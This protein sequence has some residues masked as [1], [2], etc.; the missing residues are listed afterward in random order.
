[1]TSKIV[2]RSTDVEEY[3]GVPNHYL[4][5]KLDNKQRKVDKHAEKYLSSFM[6]K[7]EAEQ[8]VTTVAGEAQPFLPCVLGGET[9]ASRHFDNTCDPQSNEEI[10]AFFTACVKWCV[11]KD[12]TM[13]LVLACHGSNSKENYKLQFEGDAKLVVP[14]SAISEGVRSARKKYPSFKCVGLIEACYANYFDVSCFDASITGGNGISRPNVLQDPLL[15]CMQEE[16]FTLGDIFVKMSEK[17]ALLQLFDCGD[18]NVANFTSAK[19][20]GNYRFKN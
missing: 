16:E 20:N 10:V 19:I 1:M 11:E 7:D 13:L 8:Q 6:S 18:D 4:T 12:K 9:G 15:Q 14:S 2:K 5:R 17:F 3:D